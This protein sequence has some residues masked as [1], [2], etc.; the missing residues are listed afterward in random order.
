M[1]HKNDIDRNRDIVGCVGGHRRLKHSINSVPP[2]TSLNCWSNDGRPQYNQCYCDNA[3]TTKYKNGEYTTIN[4]MSVHQI[5]AAIADDSILEYHFAGG[6]LFPEVRGEGVMVRQMTRGL[7]TFYVP[8]QIHEGCEPIDREVL[9][10]LVRTRRAN[11][12]RISKFDQ[13]LTYMA[14]FGRQGQ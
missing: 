14:N 1:F 9:T 10:I 4:L 12:V 7:F 8:Y 11:L 2:G 6:W 13:I 5:A 3:A